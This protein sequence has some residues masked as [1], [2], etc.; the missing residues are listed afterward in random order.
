MDAA[1]PIGAALRDM[2]REYVPR[3]K[4]LLEESWRGEDALRALLQQY[5]AT[6]RAVA[7]FVE[8]L[9]LDDVQRLLTACRALLTV[10]ATR[11]DASVRQLVQAAVLYL[12]LEE[13]DEEITG[14]LG[15]D[16]DAQVVNA[17]CRSLGHDEWVVTLGPRYEG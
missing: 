10:T 5:E 2:P 8:F 3:F 7:P 4:A 13:D 11:P 1:D 15:L 12:V 16:D 6:V 9:N 17:A 14:V